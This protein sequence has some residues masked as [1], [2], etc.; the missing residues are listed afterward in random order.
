MGP[1]RIVGLVVLPDDSNH[2]NVVDCLVASFVRDLAV[3]APSAFVGLP[4]RHR[5]DIAF[6][7]PDYDAR[8]QRTGIVSDRTIQDI[9]HR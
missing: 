5:S 3:A 9:C 8:A 4:D 6:A 1:I 2:G 7:D